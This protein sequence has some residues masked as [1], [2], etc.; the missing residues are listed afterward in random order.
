MLKSTKKLN[1]IEQELKRI[2]TFLEGDEL[3]KLKKDSEEL[4]KIKELLSHVHF[5]I[6][7]VHVVDNTSTNYPTIVVTYE[8]PKIILDIDE[9]GNPNKNDFFYSTNMLNM[10]SLDDMAKF[11]DKLRIARSK[12]NRKE[13]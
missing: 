3:A 11:Q 8:L 10:I 4:K 7:D 1:D 2:S 5:K 9:D 6:K 13:R 12:I